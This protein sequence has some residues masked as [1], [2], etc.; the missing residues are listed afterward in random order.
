MNFTSLP[1]APGIAIACGIAILAA[2]AA[3]V[4]N[5]RR[6]DVPVSERAADLDTLYEAKIAE[7]RD[8]KNA[9]D[10]LPEGV[11]AETRQRLEREAAA[12]LRARRELPAVPPQAAS[13]TRPLLQGILIGV[14][15]SGFA[16]LVFSNL[17]PPPSAV[18]P[19]AAAAAP[20]PRI[21]KLSAAVNANPN[22]YESLAELTLLLMRR[23]AFDEAAPMSVRLSMLDPFNVRGRIARE[24]FSALESPSLQAARPYIERLQVLATRYPEAYDA[25]FFAGLMLADSGARTEAA[26]ELDS[27]LA[28]A[29]DSDRPPMLKNVVQELRSRTK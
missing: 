17:T 27:Y 14:V 6:T 13:Q 15:A 29:P 18:P 21:T 7:L 8:H 24:V 19:P 12:L 2:V 20:D 1:E 22:D 10:L 28:K 11:H 9:A 26:D 25:H 5:R 23:Q 3:L 16:A 4:Y